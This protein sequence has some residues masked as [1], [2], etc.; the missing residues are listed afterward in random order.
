M[1]KRIGNLRQQF[2]CQRQHRA[3]YES[4]ADNNEDSLKHP[5]QD[6]AHGLFHFVTGVHR[7]SCHRN[8][9]EHKAEDNANQCHAPIYLLHN[10]VANKYVHQRLRFAVIADHGLSAHH[11][12]NLIQNTDNPTK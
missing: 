5:R 8:N 9:R 4:Q 10:T 1:V 3:E 2:I 12:K 11:G 6:V 7:F